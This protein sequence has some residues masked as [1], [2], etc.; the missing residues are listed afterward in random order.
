MTTM[1]QISDEVVIEAAIRLL[2]QKLRFIRCLSQRVSSEEYSRMRLADRYPSE[3]IPSWFVAC[4][5]EIAADS[6][7]H[8]FPNVLNTAY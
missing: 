7:A 5:R 1:D 2:Q 4:T 6:I 3:T 8:L